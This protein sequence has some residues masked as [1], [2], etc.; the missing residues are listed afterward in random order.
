MLPADSLAVVDPRAIRGALRCTASAFTQ[1]AARQCVLPLGGSL[2]SAWVATSLS[3]ALCSGQVVSVLGPPGLVVVVPRPGPPLSGSRTARQRRGHLG[4]GCRHAATAGHIAFGGAGAS[5]F[6]RGIDAAHVWP[7]IVG[8]W[9]L[10]PSDTDQPV[11]QMPSVCPPHRWLA[12]A[13][14]SKASVGILPGATRGQGPQSAQQKAMGRSRAAPP[15]R[16]SGNAVLRQR[17]ESQALEARMITFRCESFAFQSRSAGASGRT[18]TA[19]LSL[20]NVFFAHA[21]VQ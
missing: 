4:R 16:G 13:A 3:I 12:A 18:Q 19:R 20:V 2:L 15:Q 7:M 10:G 11:E 6:T 9:N 5:A 1:P 21:C 8:A 17:R 14:P